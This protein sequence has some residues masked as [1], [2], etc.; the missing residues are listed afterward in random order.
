MECK[1]ESKRNLPNMIIGSIRKCTIASGK[2]ASLP[3]GESMLTICQGQYAGPKESTASARAWHINCGIIPAHPQKMLDLLS[4][5]RLS[6]Q[7]SEKGVRWNL[8]PLK[9]KPGSPAQDI[10]VAAFIPGLAFPFLA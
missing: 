8:L 4:N 2:V 3:H 6:K 1:E 9:P 10:E 5:K 7:P